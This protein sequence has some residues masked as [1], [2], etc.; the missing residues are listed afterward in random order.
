MSQIN[1]VSAPKL[2]PEERSNRIGIPATRGGIITVD[3]QLTEYF[4][5]IHVGVGGNVIVRGK[6]NS[7]IPVLGLSD[8]S[9]FPAIGNEV[10]SA[11]TIDGVAVTTTAENI[12]WYGGI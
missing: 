3:T 4:K 12:T 9:W 6:D 1:Q 8:D 7:M 10:V 5:L 2:P 11:A